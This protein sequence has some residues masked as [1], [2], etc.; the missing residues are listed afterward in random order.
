MKSLLLFLVLFV[1]TANSQIKIGTTVPV[2][3]DKTEKYDSTYN[4]PKGKIYSLIGQDLYVK[5]LPERLK[6][7]GYRYFFTDYLKK[8]VYSPNRMKFSESKSLEGKV[9]RLVNIIAID[10]TKEDEFSHIEGLDHNKN[11]Y[12]QLCSDSETIYFLYNDAFS[13]YPFLSVGY[14]EG[15]KNKNLQKEFL[16][17]KR[18]RNIEYDYKTGKE[19]LLTPL[20]KWVCIDVVLDPKSFDVKLVLKN[21]K[22]DEIAIDYN[23][24]GLYMKSKDICETYRQLYGDNYMLAMHNEICIG[25][26]SILVLFAWGE[27]MRIN[28]TADEDQWVYKNQYVYINKEGKVSYFN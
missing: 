18:D 3:P 4:Y 25:M 22:N 8:Q 23:N 14:F 7:F 17:K 1:G 15:I 27:P 28:T 9:F 20:E 16:Y 6:I 5:P 24:H 10:K 21:S 26:E 2:V 11:Y 19:V 13:A 12:L